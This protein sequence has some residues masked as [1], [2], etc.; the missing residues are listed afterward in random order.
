[1]LETVR[2]LARPEDANRKGLSRQLTPFLPL[3]SSSTPFFQT[4]KI[5]R[6]AELSPFIVFIAP[7]DQGTQVGLK[8]LCWVVV[9]A[10][11]QAHEDRA[12]VR[13]VGQSA[14]RAQLPD[15]KPNPACCCP[16]PARPGAR[17]RVPVPSV[18]HTVVNALARPLLQKS[19]S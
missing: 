14:G 16:L 10:A 12:S 5:V 17:A 9:G 6:T 4:L 8:G 3:S 11:L 15:P 19:R 1:M 7:T 18:Q 13:I 2:G